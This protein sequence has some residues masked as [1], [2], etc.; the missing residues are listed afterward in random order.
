MHADLS[1]EPTRDRLH[2][3]KLLAPGKYTLLFLAAIAVAALFWSWLAWNANMPVWGMTLAILGVLAL[4]LGLKWHADLRQYGVAAAVLGVLL[5]LQSFHMLEHV[6][7]VIQFYVLDR[8]GALSFGLLSALNAEWV[9]FTWNWFVFGL[10][11]F[12]MSRGLR[13]PWAWVLLTWSL[14]HSLEHTYM[15]VRHYMVLNELAQ[16]GILPLPVAHALPGILGR[17]G[18]LALESFCGRIPGFTT[19]PRVSIHFWW[20][21]GETVLLFLAAWYGLPRLLAKQNEASHVP[22]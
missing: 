14:L 19:E 15:L 1:P 20:N 17:D 2:L 22:E 16:M 3:G 4:P 9:H 11:I 18:W 21:A 8:P 10:L 13:N 7:Q 6:V 5:F 12:L